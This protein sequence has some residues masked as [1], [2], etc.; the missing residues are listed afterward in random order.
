M[1]S[2]RRAFQA[3]L[4]SQTPKE[5]Q[6]DPQEASQEVLENILFF[7]NFLVREQQGF[8]GNLLAVPRGRFAATGDGSRLAKRRINR[9]TTYTLSTTGLY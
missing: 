8:A 5:T 4:A 1:S 6:T 3:Q 7:K 2:N 9:Y